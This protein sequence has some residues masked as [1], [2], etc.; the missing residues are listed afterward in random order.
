MI[1]TEAVEQANEA[2]DWVEKAQRFLREAEAHIRLRAYHEPDSPVFEPLTFELNKCLA[3]A[4]V[5]LA[6]AQ[7]VEGCADP[8]PPV[9]VNRGGPT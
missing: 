9:W 7:S 8:L 6:E 5:A 4:K 1:R 3:L 2:L